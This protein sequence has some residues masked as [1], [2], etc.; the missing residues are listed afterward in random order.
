MVLPVA[1]GTRMQVRSIKT[2]STPKHPA[3][4]VSN[5]MVPYQ[6]DYHLLVCTDDDPKS[7]TGCDVGACR[8][9]KRKFLNGG[10]KTGEA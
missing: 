8:L 10:I 2:N 1:K 4:A 7:A 5:P 6:R 9:E 3:I